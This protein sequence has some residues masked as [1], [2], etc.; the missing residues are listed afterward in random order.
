MQKITKKE[1]AEK[2]RIITE[3]WDFYKDSMGEMAALEVACQ[4]HGVDS[5]W[6]F[7][8]MSEG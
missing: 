4:Q 6:Y 3:D 5:D 7:E 8:N 1:I 2:I